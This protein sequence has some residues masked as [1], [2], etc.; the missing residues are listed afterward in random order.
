MLAAALT[1]A[2][3]LYLDYMSKF[4]ESA[5]KV[6]HMFVFHCVERSSVVG[7]VPELDQSSG[8]RIV[9]SLK[10]LWVSSRYQ[11]NESKS[12]KGPILLNTKEML[13]FSDNDSFL[14]L[15]IVHRTLNVVST[16]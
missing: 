2:L 8:H 5:V 7:V 3:L 4:L 15:W 6:V 1:V 12:I 9:L 13:V 16:V 11:F 14:K 10:Y